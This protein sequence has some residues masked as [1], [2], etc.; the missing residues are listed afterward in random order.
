MGRSYS[1]SQRW[2]AGWE[3][4]KERRK[5]RRRIRKQNRTV[6]DETKF[7]KRVKKF[8]PRVMEDMSTVPNQMYMDDVVG[9]VQYVIRELGP[10]FGHKDVEIDMELVE[11]LDIAMT[12][13]TEAIL[14]VTGK[15]SVHALTCT[16]KYI[17]DSK[18]Q[19]MRRGAF[20]QFRGHPKVVPEPPALAERRTDMEEV[21]V[22]KPQKQSMVTK[23]RTKA[24][25][26]RETQIPTPP[27]LPSHEDLCPK[28]TYK[29]TVAKPI[30][31]PIVMGEPNKDESWAS[32]SIM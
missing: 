9:I 2:N 17:K 20:S 25:E 7:V 21:V 27:P 22:P 31:N 18:K 6:K 30:S 8:W 15:N 5:E 28:T 19:F 24:E 16:L 32:C 3:A 14:V 12:I 29:I 4:K 26:S 23:L 10:E 11:Q 1:K 13:L